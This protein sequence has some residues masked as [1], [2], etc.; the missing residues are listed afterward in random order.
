MRIAQSS[1]TQNGYAPSSLS[2]TVAPDLTVLSPDQIKVFNDAREAK[3]LVSWVHKEYERA[4]SARQKYERQ[5][6]LN[7]AMYTGKQNMTYF[8][9][10]NGA[11][12]SGLLSNPPTTPYVSRRVFNRIRPI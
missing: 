3:N 1:M 11:P 9:A 7:M 5:W 4:K 6:A 10:R 12:G 2:Q 8:P